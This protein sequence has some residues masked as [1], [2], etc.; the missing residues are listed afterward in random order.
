MIACSDGR[1][2]EEVDEFIRNGLGIECYDRLYVPGGAGALASSSSESTRAHN[3]RAECRFLI[4][5]HG[6]E[7]VILLFHGPSADGPDTATC[8]DYR[9]K[10][11]GRPAQEICR[12][13]EE[14]ANEMLQ[15]G[16]GR[17]VRLRAYRAEVTRD[18]SVQFVPLHGQAE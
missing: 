18:D 15:T 14:D 8:A 4:S 17:N 1:F 5:A 7:Q 16:L 10:L 6:T 11:P 12:Q 3:F 13:Q 9:R 2:R